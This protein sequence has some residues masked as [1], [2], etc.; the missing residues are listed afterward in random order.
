MYRIHVTRRKKPAEQP[1]GAVIK[2][3]NVLGSQAAGLAVLPCSPFNVLRMAS[4][5]TRHDSTD[6]CRTSSEEKS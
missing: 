1:L 5:C 2:T 4:Y 6:K 3:Y